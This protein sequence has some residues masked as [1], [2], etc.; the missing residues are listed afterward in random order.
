MADIIIEDPNKIIVN[1]DSPVVNSINGE[2]GELSVK[3]INNESILGEGDI[4]IS[5]GTTVEANPAE[6]TDTLS[7]ITIGDTSYSIAGGGSG[8]L[9]LSV[10]EST[11]TFTLSDSEQGTSVTGYDTDGVNQ[12]SE[13]IPSG[14]D[15]GAIAITYVSQAYPMIKEL[16]AGGDG[17][18]TFKATVDNGNITY[19]WVLDT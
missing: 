13:Q 4:E 10:D 3:T 7:S 2:S 18:Y 15:I 19:S 11:H 9:A 6:T 12:I 17:T 1:D 8:S 16:P 5:G 14:N